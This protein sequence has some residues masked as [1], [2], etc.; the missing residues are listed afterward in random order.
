MIQEWNVETNQIKDAIN[1]IKELIDVHDG[2]KKV[3]YVSTVEIMYIIRTTKW[4]LK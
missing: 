3:D 2:Y 1:M 4:L